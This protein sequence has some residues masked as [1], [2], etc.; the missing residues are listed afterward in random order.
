M[1]KPISEEELQLKIRARRRIIGAVTLVVLMV[2]FLPMIF[3]SQPK[4]VAKELA[5]KTPE[6]EKSP[7]ITDATVEPSQLSRNIEKPQSSKP[8]AIAEVK[9][10]PPEEQIK[11]PE[12][13]IKKVKP[14]SVEPVITDEKRA[15][16]A[17]QQ[18]KIKQAVKLHTEKEADIKQA[19]KVEKKTGKFFVQVGVFSNPTNVAQIEEKLQESGVKHSKEKLR[20]ST[21]GA[22]KVRAGPFASRNEAEEAVAQLKLAGVSNG[23]IVSE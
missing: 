21:T 7:S 23:V 6:I 22:V 17:L 2:I 5:L 15:E 18:E 13:E 14:S 19:D 1:S 10:F 3:D 4:H 16:K 9:P 20:G 12:E 8:F 11:P